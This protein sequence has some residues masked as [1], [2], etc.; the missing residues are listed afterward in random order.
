MHIPQ[1]R[2]KGRPRSTILGT[3]VGDRDVDQSGIWLSSGVPSVRVH[4]PQYHL[5]LLLLRQPLTE[6]LIEMVLQHCR[7]GLIIGAKDI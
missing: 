4:L 3:S 7:P 5:V 6:T 2:A 1:Q